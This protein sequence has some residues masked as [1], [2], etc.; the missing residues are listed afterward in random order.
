MDA[1]IHVLCVDDEPRVTEALAVHLRRHFRVSTAPNGQAALA[2]V[3]SRD[4]PVVVVSDMRMPEMDGAELLSQV[5]E[6]SPSTVRIL[7]TGQA[8]IACA[9]AAVNHGQIFRFLTK[10]CK[11]ETLV[12][13]VRAAADQHRLMT[14]ARVLLEETLGGCV[15]VLTDLLALTNPLAFGRAIRLKRLAADLLAASGSP[16]AWNVEV[17]AMLSQVGAITLS[18]ETNAKLYYGKP[19]NRT[20]AVLVRQLP[21]FA[22]RILD[23]IPRLESVRAI[24]QHAT[25]NFDGSGSADGSL[26]GATLPLGARILKIVA[27]YDILQAAGH[28]PADA[29]AMLRNRKGKYDPELLAAFAS[30]EAATRPRATCDLP[31]RALRPRMHFS[32]DVSSTSATMLVARGQEVTVALLQRLHNLP[33]GTVREPLTVLVPPET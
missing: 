31:L 32:K 1:P 21:A 22:A 20:E 19:L 15:R 6:R 2:V 10:P 9:V 29:I 23:G 30:V 28:T 16:P 4:P 18:A 7:L 11:T 33:A 17:A 27:A 24:L 26:K 12:A 14:T 3:D 25:N 8:D 13:A 5:R